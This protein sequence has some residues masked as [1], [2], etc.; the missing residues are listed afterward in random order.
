MGEGEDIGSPSRVKGE[1]GMAGVAMRFGLS[2]RVE[3]KGVEVIH[4]F[5]TTTIV[6]LR[7]SNSVD[8]YTPLSC[9]DTIPRIS[10]QKIMA[11]FFI[12]DCMYLRLRG[13]R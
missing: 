1:T 9:D 11:E 6:L 12:L 5:L 2:A 13:W 3:G 7:D 8:L 4:I 10:L